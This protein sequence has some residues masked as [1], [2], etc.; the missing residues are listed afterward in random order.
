MIM[1]LDPQRSNNFP[2]MELVSYSQQFQACK[3]C[4]DR[5]AQIRYTEQMLRENSDSDCLA[6][7]TRKH[8]KGC[9]Y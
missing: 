8:L 4:S 5:G 9:N 6:R 1:I 2:R 3:Q 7:Y